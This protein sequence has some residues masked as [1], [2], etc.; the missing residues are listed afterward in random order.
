MKIIIHTNELL[1]RERERTP[2]GDFVERNVDIF[3]III[4]TFASDHMSQRSYEVVIDVT[5]E[6]TVN[7]AKAKIPTT[8]EPSD[9]H[10]YIVPIPPGPIIRQ[11][12]D[13]IVV[14][15]QESPHRVLVG[16]HKIKDYH[17]GH[18]STVFIRFGQYTGSTI[19]AIVHNTCGMVDGNPFNCK[20]ITIIVKPCKGIFS[21]S[22]FLGGLVGGVIRI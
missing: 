1:A 18:N 20:P 22:C 3:P 21:G 15:R 19:H 10:L 16:D 9:C 4:K 5:P 2:R 7:E 6:M 17:L 14:M 13:N 11:N 12:I 8:L